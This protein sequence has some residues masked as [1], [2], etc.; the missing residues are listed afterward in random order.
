MYSVLLQSL[1]MAL[2]IDSIR[3]FPTPMGNTLTDNTE[4]IG[5]LITTPTQI[6][7]F[8]KLLTD[9]SGNKLLD[10]DQLTNA[11]IWDFEQN[12]FPIP[13]GQGGDASSAN[14]ETFPYLINSG[15]TMTMGKLGPCGIFLPHVHPRAN[16]FFVVTEGEVDFGTL[17]ELG[18]FKDLSPNPEIR[19]KLTKN[20]G[21]LFPK[22]SIH[23]QLNNNPDCKPATI[24]T[25]L[26]SEDAGSTPI[27]MD[28]LPSNVTVGAGMRKRVDAGDFESVRGVTPLHIA[29]I[30]DE[31]LARCHVS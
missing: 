22:G 9:E 10:D 31:C 26:T 4:L 3:A 13:G 2:A 29:K 17:L 30:V 20:K 14:L 5:Q 8:Q 1:A 15:V 12:G 28:S 7:R 25:A 18:L 6:K 27:F 19:G 24:Y 23:Y 21:T 11:T 16:E